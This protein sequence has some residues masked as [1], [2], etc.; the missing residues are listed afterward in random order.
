M[1]DSSSSSTSTSQKIFAPGT[2]EDVNSAYSAYQSQIPGWNEL[3]SALQGKS[4]ESAAQSKQL[5]GQLGAASATE[6]QATN[7]ITDTQE[8]NRQRILSVTGTSSMDPESPI[9]K[10]YQREAVASQMLEHLRPKVQELQNAD[11][12]QNPLQWLVSQM[13]LSGVAGQW[14]SAVQMK[15]AAASEIASH[16]QRAGA[17][18][19]IEQAVTTDERKRLTEASIKRISLELKL[20]EQA[21][22]ERD[23]NN[24]MQIAGLRERMFG[25]QFSNAVTRARLLSEQQQLSEV[26]R[27][28][29]DEDDQLEAINKQLQKFGHQGIPSLKQ[30]KLL[31]KDQQEYITNTLLEN[32]TTLA[33][34]PGK[35]LAGLALFPD[36][37]RKLR[38]EN[39][40]AAVYLSDMAQQVNKQISLRDKSGVDPAW[41]K[42]KPHEKIEIVGNE[43][44]KGWRQ[45]LTT[46]SNEELKDGNI[47]KMQ[48]AVFASNPVLVNN[49]VA[50]F[51]REQK[52]ITGTT[53][54]MQEI[55]SSTLAAVK[56][57]KPLAQAEAELHEFMVEGYGYQMFRLGGGA[58]G[59]DTSDPKSK[60]G[61]TTYRI[62]PQDI[63]PTVL[64]GLFS[65]RPDDIDM[66]NPNGIHNLL[67]LVN[68]KVAG[69]DRKVSPFDY[70]VRKD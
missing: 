28:R 6:L 51:V 45:E 33:G 32:P 47:Y 23:T 49:P 27:L 15:S 54:G 60:K 21:I 38:A 69:S 25:Q 8:A 44:A 5:I 65:S 48:P 26:D 40:S 30:F 39:P 46:K 35:A 70:T 31:D 50:R 42:L 11:W 52:E 18:L 56:A 34:T 14:N 3:L 41:N 68:S 62:N 37:L 29:K 58:L 10:A 2:V 20:K 17:Q 24:Q 7:A 4:A 63:T 43:I 13:K 12:T 16:Q 59:L 22:E 9:M 67:V 36:A 55:V 66:L 61:D 19:Q 64:W 57:G 1:A 53:P